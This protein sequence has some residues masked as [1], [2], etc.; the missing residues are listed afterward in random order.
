[1]NRHAKTVIALMIAAVGFSGSCLSAADPAPAAAKAPT[2]AD[3]ARAEQA[4]HIKSL[5]ERLRSG[6]PEDEQQAIDELKTWLSD[7]AKSAKDAPDILLRL[8][9]A[10]SN[11]KR[12]TDALALAQLVLPKVPEER[13]DQRRELTSMQIRSQMRLKQFDA[14]MAAY[15]KL[16]AV[17]G[18]GQLHQLGEDLQAYLFAGQ[19]YHDV[20]DLSVQL[21]LAKPEDTPRVEGALQTQIKAFNLEK[22]Y[23]KALAA[24]KQLLWVS[25]MPHT[26]EALLA[27]ARQLALAH[28]EDKDIVEK[29]RQ[30]QIDGAKPTTEP[31]DVVRTSAVLP[32]I[33]V[34]ATP[35]EAAVKDIVDGDYDS[36][37]R[38]GNLL[39]LTDKPKE[40]KVAFE[41]ALALSMDKQGAASTAA[42]GV[43]R[44][45]RAQD[46][47]VGRANAFAMSV[48]SGK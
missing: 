27:V 24:S 42:E 44:S 31:T 4:A 7:D 13:A 32:Q 15:K 38:L 46:G 12:A 9:T 1:M 43:A 21:I 5:D 19:R 11:P 17:E 20:E 10:I 3:L 26:G 25:T 18:P 39:L 28:P 36:Q 45:I 2:A 40:A 34:D 48:S 47:T 14:G 6:K 29:F 22:R 33:K 37:M 41:T 30:E 23:D 16:L 35:Y 8:Q